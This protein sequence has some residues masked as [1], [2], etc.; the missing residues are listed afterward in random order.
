VQFTE[1][2]ALGLRASVLTLSH[3]SHPTTFVLCPVVH[4]GERTYYEAVK[5][6]IAGCDTLIHE[7]VR[8]FAAALL[9]QAYTLV[10]RRKRL[11]L[12]TQSSVL[13]DA[14]FPG[15]RIHA[16]V[17][18]KEFSRL[19]RLIP[20]CSRLLLSALAPVYGG[21]LYLTAS[22]S[23]IARRTGREDLEARDDLIRAVDNPE[24]DRALL[25]SRDARLIAAIDAIVA[26]NPV[27]QRVAVVYGAGHM[28]VVTQR[29][30]DRHGYRIADS[31]WL[32][33]LSYDDP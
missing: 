30:L 28:R 7:G 14:D 5:A 31:E 2:S 27:A 21:W 26:G 1:N 4:I 10:A 23:S 22:R 13:R 17:D 19:W 33:V 12:V 8:S 29:L 18:S 9:T 3:S 11:G 32:T 25:G 16:D 20:W 6:R 24:L 15:R